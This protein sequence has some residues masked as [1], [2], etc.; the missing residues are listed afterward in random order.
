MPGSLPQGT[1]L[2]S[3]RVVSADGHPIGGALTFSVG[4]PSAA[5][6]QNRQDGGGVLSTAIWLIRFALYIGLFVGVG[7]VYYARR[8][9][10]HPLTAEVEKPIAF[11]LDLGLV[12]A[13]VSVGL[14]GADALGLP[15]SELYRPRVWLDGLST[16][17][18]VT[19]ASAVAALLIGRI[20]LRAPQ[21]RWLAALALGGV[22]AALAASGH[23]SAAAPQLVTRPLVF[24]H[25][26]T[27]AFWIGS[28]W[29]LI[30]AARA[31]SMEELARFS[32]AIPWPLALL[33]ASG[34]VLAVIQVQEP[35]ALLGTDYGR[36]LLAKLAAAAVLLALAL[37]SRIMTAR[38]GEGGSKRL[39]SSVKAE[40]LLALVILGIVASWRF[41]PPPRSLLVA[42][43]QPVQVH[44]HTDKAMA[45]LTIARSEAGGRS[46]AMTLLDG[47]FGPLAAKEVSVFLSKPDAGIEPIRLQA[48]HVDATIWR[49]DQVQLPMPGRWH[50]RIEILVSDFDKVAVEDEIDLPR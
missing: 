35:G 19:A 45:D 14:Q 10:A 24:V 44:I 16:S 43:A 20:A 40:L 30:S 11:A 41:T 4:Q 34:A 47:Q 17:Y 15:L 2:L 38:A 21:P 7:G 32:R 42:A 26:V 8:V 28:L 33:I 39:A 6:P 12:A 1:H 29:P 25:G 46:I 18:G 23:A 49:V 3:W 22:G 5:Q 31:G 9:A 50:V 48:K 27:V 37:A 13:V 36:V